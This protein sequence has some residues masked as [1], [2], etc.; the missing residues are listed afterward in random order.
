[1]KISIKFTSLN[2][3]ES[4][5]IPKKLRLYLYGAAYDA[6]GTRDGIYLI[7]TQP[8]NGFPCWVQE[9]GQN[10]IWFDDFNGRWNIGG[11]EERGKD[12]CAVAGPFSFDE[13]PNMIYSFQFYDGTQWQTDTLNR[14]RIEDFSMATGM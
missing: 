7:Q 8:I 10:A 13:W 12:I 9:S 3:S 11:F 14:I 2:S 6:Q 5:H 1:M 4:L